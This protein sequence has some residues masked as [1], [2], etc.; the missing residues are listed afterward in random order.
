MEMGNC[1]CN[2]IGRS[3]T[4]TCFILLNAS[5]EVVWNNTAYI[6]TVDENKI[7]SNEMFG[8]VVGRLLGFPEEIIFLSSSQIDSKDKLRIM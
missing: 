2:A 8:E 7:E 3:I 6:N 5:G 4:Y 1:F